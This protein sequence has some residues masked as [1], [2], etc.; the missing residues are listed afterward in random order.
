M[1]A[2]DATPPSTGPASAPT[3]AAA[4][5]RPISVPRRSAGA[6]DTSQAS[7]PV[8]V[9]A[10]ARPCTKRA[11]S[12]CHAVSAIPNSVVQSATALSPTITPRFDADA[13]GDDPARDRAHDHPRRVGR[14]EHAGA[15]LAQVQ[16][17]RV[18]RQQ[19]RQ[20]GEEERVEEDD[21]ARQEEKSPDGQ[22]A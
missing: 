18:V 20:R 2:T 4:N 14:S 1:P 3:T 21:G 17:V 15:G 16:R 11:V 6:A 5:A 9:K 13:G 19:R 10:L 7:A 8:Q 12:S 22:G